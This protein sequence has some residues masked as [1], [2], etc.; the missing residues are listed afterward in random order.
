MRIRSLSLALIGSSLAVAACAGFCQHFGQQAVVAQITF[1]QTPQNRNQPQSQNQNQRGLPPEQKKSLSRYGPEDVFPSANE[2]EES[3]R[4]NT[5]SRQRSQ[6]ASASRPSP[7]PRQSPT[8]AT[9]TSPA[10]AQPAAAKPSPTM[11]AAL[12]NQLQQAPPAQQSASANA[13]SQWAV[14][15]LSGLALIVTIALIYVLTKLV[16]KIREDSRV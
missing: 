11:V 9:A 14:P 8:P 2:Q 10:A 15:V 12:G 13:A 6:R 5:G 1:V 4:R 3:R 7:A 16:G